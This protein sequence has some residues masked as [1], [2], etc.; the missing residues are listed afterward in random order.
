M[1]GGVLNL[2]KG[3]GV[4]MLISKFSLFYFGSLHICKGILYFGLYLYYVA[5]NDV[6]AFAEMYQLRQKY[7]PNACGSWNIKYVAD[8][9]I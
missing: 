5:Q 4:K 7:V 9:Q 3:K 2:K 1:I 8:I 6:S